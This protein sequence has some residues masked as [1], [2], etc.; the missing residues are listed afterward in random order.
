[1]YSTIPLKLANYGSSGGSALWLKKAG[2]AGP[3]W[4]VVRT[5][6]DHR[7]QH[8]HG[9]TLPCLQCARL[10]LCPNPVRSG[11]RSDIV[12]PGSADIVLLGV[13]VAGRDSPWRATE[14]GT[15]LIIQPCKGGYSVPDMDQQPARLSGTGV[16]DLRNWSRQPSVTAWLPSISRSVERGPA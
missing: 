12:R 6:S 10:S 15:S 9:T 5:T 2:H 14:K 16:P 1:M 11:R 7:S 8:V 3:I 4:V 13:R